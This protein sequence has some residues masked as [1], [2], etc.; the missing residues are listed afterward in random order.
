[1]FKHMLGLL[2]VC[3]LLAPV[4]VQAKEPTEKVTKETP[5]KEKLTKEKAAK[6][7]KANREPASAKGKPKPDPSP[8]PVKGTGK[9]LGE[10]I[11]YPGFEKD[12]K[13]K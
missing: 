12:K 1:M 9:P 10:T 2:C 11:G 5:S 8:K 3:L 13:N 6:E 4:L 7:T